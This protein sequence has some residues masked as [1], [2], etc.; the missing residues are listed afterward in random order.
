M[1][2]LAIVFIK[3]I[4]RIQSRARW[5]LKSQPKYLDH[6]LILFKGMYVLFFEMIGSNLLFDA[7]KKGKNLMVAAELCASFESCVHMGLV[8]STRWQQFSKDILASFFGKMGGSGYA[9]S[10]LY[11]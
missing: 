10:V 7:I 8:N 11:L 5:T 2:V 9:S 3:N 4:G 6:S 1:I